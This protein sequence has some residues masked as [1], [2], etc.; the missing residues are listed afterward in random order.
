VSDLG[1]SLL[2]EEE[3]A[4][5]FRKYA[6]SGEWWIFILAWSYLGF[7]L[8]IE[9]RFYTPNTEANDDLHVQLHPREPIVA[10]GHKR[11]LSREDLSAVLRE[12]GADERALTT[13]GERD[14]LWL[15]VTPAVGAK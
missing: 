8:E 12:G 2:G 10:F 5:A 11:H 1:I 14:I 7:L 13:L 4:R 15:G 3:A 6:D 9:V